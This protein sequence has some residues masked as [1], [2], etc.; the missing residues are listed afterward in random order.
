MFETIKKLFKEEDDEDDRPTDFTETTI[1]IKDEYDPN[2]IVTIPELVGSDYGTVF[3]K[4]YRYDHPDIWRKFNS[5]ADFMNHMKYIRD[6]YHV[7]AKT[8][9]YSNKWYNDNVFT[10]YYYFTKYNRDNKTVWLNLDCKDLKNLIFF[11]EHDILLELDKVIKEWDKAYECDDF[12]W[13]DLTKE[14][15]LENEEQIE[16]RKEIKNV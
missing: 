6:L 11:R 2:D 15:L 12:Q 16:N 4:K 1:I 7:L 10:P 9:Y 14:K 13:L 8:C 3:S 5:T